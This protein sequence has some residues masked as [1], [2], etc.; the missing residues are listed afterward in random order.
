VQQAKLRADVTFDGDAMVIALHGE[1]DAAT[2]QDIRPM[3]DHVDWD[4]LSEVSVDLRR[5]GFMDSTALAMLIDLQQ[6]ADDHSTPLVLV[7][8]PPWVGRV[9]DLT[10]TTAQFSWVDGSR[11]DGR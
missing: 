4:S 11:V 6:R 2:C 3:L 7:A 10:G 5:V 9:F 1:I 8:G